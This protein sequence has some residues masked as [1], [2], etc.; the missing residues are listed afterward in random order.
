M[1]TDVTRDA[2]DESSSSPHFCR[3]NLR[4]TR[5]LDVSVSCSFSTHRQIKL[6]AESEQDEVVFVARR[7]DDDNFSC[8]IGADDFLQNSGEA[9]LLLWPQL[10]VVRV[11][12]RRWRSFGSSNSQ[13]ENVGRYSIPYM[14]QCAVGIQAGRQCWIRSAGVREESRRSSRVPRSGNQARPFGYASMYILPFL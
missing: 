10:G 1:R 9:S 4:C 6:T 8:I 13:E 5:T 11:R 2:P 3:P 14:P 12:R 7:R